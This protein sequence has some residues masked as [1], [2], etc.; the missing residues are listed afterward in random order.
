MAIKTVRAKAPQRLNEFIKLRRSMKNAED[1]PVR[2]TDNFEPES[3]K[4]LT[5]LGFSR[6]EIHSAINQLGTD[7]VAELQT[8]LRREQY[9]LALE[10]LL[11]MGFS[12]KDA[13]KGLS[14]EGPQNLE[15]IVGKLCKLQE[16][17]LQRDQEKER[18]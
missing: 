1:Q 11:Q 16:K 4:I 12:E 7:D 8:F 18:I 9:D 6:D 14:R 10:T 17:R 2:S 13:L 3:I 15:L 5:D